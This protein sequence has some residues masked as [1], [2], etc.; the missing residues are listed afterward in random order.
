MTCDYPAIN[1]A[2]GTT[3]RLTG[4]LEI[5]SVLGALFDFVRVDSYALPDR[6]GVGEMTHHPDGGVPKFGPRSFDNEL[7][8]CEPR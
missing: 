3:S 1:E 8:V 6:L 2:Y 7:G 4:M 5:A